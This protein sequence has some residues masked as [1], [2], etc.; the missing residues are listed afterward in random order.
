[1]NRT[2]FWLLAAPLILFLV[3][4]AASNDAPVTLT[5][6]PFPF[7][8]EAPLYLFFLSLAF[9]FFIIGAVCAWIGQHR[10]RADARHYKRELEKLKAQLAATPAPV[11]PAARLLPTSDS[12]GDA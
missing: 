11:I 2:I 8:I 12:L 9:G 3:I 10:A 5:F 7:T 4:F 1:M 6:W